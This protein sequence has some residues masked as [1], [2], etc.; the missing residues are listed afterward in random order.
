MDA[1]AALAF[2][3]SMP[4]DWRKEMRESRLQGLA[5]VHPLE[6]A[7]QTKPN[8][9]ERTRVV[10]TAAREAPMKE[11]IEV[12]VQ[13]SADLEAAEMESAMMA[14]NKRDPAALKRLLEARGDPH[15]SET[16]AKISTRPDPP[17]TTG[18][19]LCEVLAAARLDPKSNSKAIGSAIMETAVQDPDAAISAWAGL[20]GKNLS[21]GDT[22]MLLMTLARHH[23]AKA[24]AFSEEHLPSGSASAVNVWLETD[25]P[26]ALRAILELP[27]SSVFRQQVVE[28]LKGNGRSR[29][30]PLLRVPHEDLLLAAQERPTEM[31]RQ[32]LPDN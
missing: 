22:V 19:S 21:P 12:L 4:G 8:D 18:R 25:A 15:L 6:A 17:E 11:V 2:E 31:L 16:L 26:R 23:P 3:K 1:E 7:R 28:E 14:L 27:Y 10:M 29:G 20:K 9:K 5:G 24:L 13:Y 32:I 30:M